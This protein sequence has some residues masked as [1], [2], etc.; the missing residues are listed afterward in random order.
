MLLV[1]PSHL[2]AGRAQVRLEQQVPQSPKFDQR[3]G[4]WARG[5]DPPPW[6]LCQFKC[7]CPMPV[8]HGHTPLPLVGVSVIVKVHM[9]LGGVWP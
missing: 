4:V 1:T 5:S 2:T 6:A 9:P 3:K 7:L 8:A